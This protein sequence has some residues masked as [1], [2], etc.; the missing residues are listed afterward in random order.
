MKQEGLKLF[1]SG[2]YEDAIKAFTALLEMPNSTDKDR[3]FYN[4][5]TCN[6]YLKKYEEAIQDLTQAV[7]INREYSKA[8]QKRAKCYE[9]LNQLE[10]ALVDYNIIYIIDLIHE[11]QDIPPQ[12]E[13]I[14][15]EVGRKRAAET[16]LRR[17]ETESVTY[18]FP[19]EHAIRVYLSGFTEPI[20]HETPTETLEELNEMIGLDSDNGDLYYNRAVIYLNQKNY[21]E[22]EQDFRF[23]LELD[24]QNKIKSLLQLTIFSIVKC[25]FL[26]AQVYVDQGLKLTN[27]NESE[28]DEKKKKYYKVF[29]YF[30][31]Q[32]KFETNK[33]SEGLEL[34]N[35]LRDK[36]PDYPDV[37]LQIAQYYFIREECD[38]CKENLNKAIELYP[39][40]G[41]AY[42]QL[43]L[44]AVKTAN[45]IDGKVN[46]EKAIKLIPDLGYIY[47]FYSEFLFSTNE[48]NLAFKMVET[49]IEKDPTFPL[50]YL[51]KAAFISQTD[52]SR[53]NE[54]NDLYKKALDIDPTCVASYEKLAMS[55]LMN[56]QC[57]D[58]IRYLN[59]AVTYCKNDAELEEIYASMVSAE[60]KK[61]ALDY[62]SKYL[63]H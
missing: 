27:N 24:S 62:A 60:G 12:I 23:A 10:D 13:K 48:L 3:I 63:S 33:S 38:K 40:C 42:F 14:S 1:K 50:N 45:Y 47:N 35:Q 32:I 39:N 30:N 2:K 31:A 8:F 21:I 29:L 11:K 57:D 22:A 9:I 49:G 26:Q 25:N 16:I 52:P 18:E 59:K 44:I 55:F 54:V 46:F 19:Q 41:M 43:A 51:T 58:A 56:M 20:Q 6:E 37:Y 36:Y 4:R 7:Q 53:Q 5:G 34:S 15:F 28:E 61:A 17:K